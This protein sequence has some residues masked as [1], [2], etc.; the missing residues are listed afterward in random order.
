MRRQHEQN[1]GN[2][3]FIS[4]YTNIQLRVPSFLLPLITDITPAP[5]SYNNH[6]ILLARGKV[7]ARLR[8]EK[9]VA[10]ISNAV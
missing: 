2:P 5:F 1:R 6:S 10:G 9:H 8:R 4:A 3:R 7:K